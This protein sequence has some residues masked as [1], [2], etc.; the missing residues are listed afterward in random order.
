M[1]KYEQF[2]VSRS[3]VLEKIAQGGELSDCLEMLCSLAEENDPGM[4]CSILFYNEVENCV[5]H[6]A[7]PSL[8]DYY[9]EAIDGLEAGVGIGSCGTAAATGK[10]VIVE[11][12]YEHDYW[13]PFRELAKKVGFSAC[14]SHPIL[15]R[16]KKVIGTFAMYYDEAKSPSEA[17][18]KLIEEQANIASLAIQNRQDR[19][20][21]VASLRRTE[22]YLNISEA[23]I[24]ELDN[25]ACV[26]RI[27]DVGLKSLGFTEDEIIGHNWFENVVPAEQQSEVLAVYER[28]MSG[29]LEPVEYYENEIVDRFGERHMISWHNRLIL[30]KDDNIVGTLSSGQD[31]TRRK[32][33][34]SQFRSAE[35]MKAI[36]QLTGGIAHDFNNLMNVAMGN[37][38]MAMGYL[39]VN[40][41]GLKHLEKTL[42]S[43]EKG[44]NLTTSLLSFSKSA[45]LEVT[46][47]SL[48]PFMSDLKERLLSTLEDDITCEYLLYGDLAACLLNPS[49][50]EDCLFKLV[51]NAKEAMPEGGV[52][53]IQAYSYSP[54]REGEYTPI[55]SEDLHS[56]HAVI[57]ISD[58]GNGMDSIV[59]K[60][61]FEPFYTTK[62]FGAGA[63]LG[64]STVFGFIKRVDGKINVASSPG[65][66]TTVELYLPIAS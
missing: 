13:A 66:G 50:L 65:K 26:V 24:V 48:R 61:M 55:S 8:P 38:E 15:S 25:K 19:E 42:Q 51:M 16:D 44:K 57:S 56:D 27:S 41:E 12:V 6:A 5:S 60:H 11:N 59:Q 28:I 17:E 64:L 46:E 37:T 3:S 30:D 23:I 21:L 47:V 49:E 43:L 20:T 22:E 58:T 62:E 34:E 63:G 9:I 36:G 18:I 39:D 7:A 33:M 54:N 40:S 45:E 32:L 10:L 2:L 14:W 1:N 35:K 4:R 31:I 52:L 53:K 29:D